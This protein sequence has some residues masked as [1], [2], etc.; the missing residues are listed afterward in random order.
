MSARIVK[1]VFSARRLGKGWL[2]VLK[3]HF[4]RGRPRAYLTSYSFPTRKEA[5]TQIA[6]HIPAI[7]ASIHHK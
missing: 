4:P 2:G 6:S 5:T 1:G 3:V 7:L